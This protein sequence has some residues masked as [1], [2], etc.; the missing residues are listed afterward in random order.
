M[1]KFIDLFFDLLQKETVEIVHV[2]MVQ[3]WTYGGH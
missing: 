3:N 1:A 2:L